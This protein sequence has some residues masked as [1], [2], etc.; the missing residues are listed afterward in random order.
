M[1]AKIFSMEPREDGGARFVL[2]YKHI[3]RS[4]IQRISCDLTQTDLLQMVLFA[5]ALN[6]HNRLGCIGC[7]NR[8]IAG[9]LCPGAAGAHS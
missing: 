1:S 2:N 5:E 9:L 7:S 6:L 4:G 3:G 8:W